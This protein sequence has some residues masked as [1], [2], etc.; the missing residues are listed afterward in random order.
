LEHTNTGNGIIPAKTN[1][2]GNHPNPFN[3]T[4]EISFA[5]S[6]AGQVIL[7]VYNLRGQ[8]VKT[9]VNDNL[10]EGYHTTVWNGKDEDGKQVSSGVYFYKMKS[11]SYLQ[12]R[13]MILMK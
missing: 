3:P 8:K 4:T 2:L 9:L 7:E 11:E 5:L 10:K 13:K 1:L 12:T 6:E